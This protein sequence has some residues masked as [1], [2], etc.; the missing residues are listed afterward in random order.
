M[1]AQSTRDLVITRVFDAPRTD[2]W[3]AWTDAERV[4]CSWG[5][6]DYTTPF[7]TIDLRPG[8]KIL[9]CMRSP[10]GRDVWST[11]V[12][13]DIDAPQR[14]VCSDAFADEKG[15]VVPA[16]Y[17]GMDVEWPADV[18]VTVTLEERSGKTTLTLKQ[19]PVPAGEFGD[20]SEA[21]WQQS[22][23]RLAACL[24]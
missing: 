20:Q 7:C 21:G 8:G 5:P 13:R 9:T 1:A 24:E 4:M 19:G 2:V 16:S 6:N 3:K 12:Y 17:Y 22:L 23:D 10:E 15:N 18:L 11:G 14:L